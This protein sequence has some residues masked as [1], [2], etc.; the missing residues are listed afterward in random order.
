MVLAIWSL[1]TSKRR[2]LYNQAI[3]LPL[4]ST[5][6]ETCGTSPSTSWAAPL[7]TTSEARLDSSPKPP[8]TGNINPATTTLASRQHQASLMIVTVRGGGVGVRSG[9]RSGMSYRVT[10]AF[11]PQEM[12]TSDGRLPVAGEPITCACVNFA[13]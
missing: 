7:A 6:F 3:T 8:T 12:A 5:I 9:G 4:A 10:R 2:W 1:G 13:S 11:A